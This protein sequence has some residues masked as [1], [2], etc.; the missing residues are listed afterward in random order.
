MLAPLFLAGAAILAGGYLIYSR[1]LDR[2]FNVSGSHRV[3][4]ETEYDGVDYVPTRAPILFGHHFASI[5]GAGPIVGP[6]IAAMAFGWLPAFIWILVG[7]ILIG[8]VHDYAALMASIRHR[9]RSIGEMAG[10][11]VSPATKKI[12][13][14]FIW[15]TLIYVLVVFLD[16]TAT[17]F[18]GNG[19]VATSSI[20]FIGLAILFGL[21]IYRLRLRTW[22]GSLIFVPL[23]FV[24][25]FVGQEIPIRATS[26]PVI[27]GSTT[28]TWSLILVVYCYLAS[29]TP[30]WVLLQPRDYLSSFLLYALV[31]ASGIGLLFGGFDIQYTPCLSFNSPIGPLFPILFVVIACGAVSGFHSVIASGTT[32]KQLASEQDV[33]KIGY[34]AMLT[35]GVVA[36]IALSTVI[37][38]GMSSQVVADYGAHKLSPL[39]VFA[40]GI[41]RFAEVYGIPARIG[42]AFGALAISTFLLTT[43]DTVTRLGR[44]LFHELFGVRQV[45]ARFLTSLAA[46]VVPV[47]FVFLTFHDAQGNVLPVWK[48]VWPVFG[49]TNQLLAGLTLLVLTVWLR[50]QGQRGL[51]VSLPMVFMFLVT[52]SGLAYLVVGGK[53]NGLV[54]GIAIAL[55]ML[56][57]V[58]IALGIRAL[59]RINGTPA[60][61]TVRLGS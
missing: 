21:S 30:V 50:R 61:E 58:M 44:F 32:A 26:L 25:I 37:M 17:T 14:S 18:A 51:F 20:I 36:L 55:F 9:G 4:A 27:A 19:G 10:R 35:E 52:L 8:G 1:I 54:E 16:L 29:V 41:G 23:V 48:A 7:A 3:P 56:A 60:A 47:I 22:I 40:A 28:R 13:L 39:G 11:I 12:F 49:A 31:V 15:L 57:I 6:I 43:L 34:G 42:S 38:L 59:R 46:L 33:K 53:Q 24:A 45:G 2:K 5:A